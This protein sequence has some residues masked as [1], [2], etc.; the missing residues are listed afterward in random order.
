MSLVR[1][2]YRNEEDD[3]SMVFEGGAGVAVPRLEEGT[4]KLMLLLQEVA[5]VKEYTNEYL[6]KL[7]LEVSSDI[8]TEGEEEEEGDGEGNDEGNDDG[9]CGSISE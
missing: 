5:A 3:T 1:G 8:A 9:A 7:I 4:A 6:S 2:V